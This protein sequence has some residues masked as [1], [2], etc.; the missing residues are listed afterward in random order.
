MLLNGDDDFWWNGQFFYRFGFGPAFILRRMNTSLER[1]SFEETQIPLHGWHEYRQAAV[2]GRDPSA[3]EAVQNK[4]GRGQNSSAAGAL[5]LFQQIELLDEF[6]LDL[7][8]PVDRS[9]PE[10]GD[11][12]QFLERHHHR[13]TDLGRFDLFDAA[14]TQV[15]FYFGGDLFDGGHGDRAFDAGHLEAADELLPV[16]FLA[17]VVGLDHPEGDLIELFAG[18]ET[19]LAFE[20][21]PPAAD[22]AAAVARARVDHFAVVIAAEWASHADIPVRSEIRACN[23][24]NISN[25]LQEFK[26]FLGGGR[27]A[28][29]V[30]ARSDS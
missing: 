25:C 26:D 1:T 7:K 19:A 22:G 20:T 11:L 10:I 12:I 27:A 21:L 24:K 8:I 23:G 18:G 9:K 14:I 28:G 29:G 17:P 13:F 6:F 30:Y 3:P 5:D 16:E 2:A 15:I 4:V